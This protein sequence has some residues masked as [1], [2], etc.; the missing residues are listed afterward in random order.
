MFL[1]ILRGMFFK[2]ENCVLCVMARMNTFCLSLWRLQCKFL[3]FLI[4]LSSTVFQTGARS[5]AE[6]ITFA[7]RETGSNRQIDRILLRCR[8]Q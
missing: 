6:M 5:R 1:I 2:I 4:Y 3:N 7:L 8:T